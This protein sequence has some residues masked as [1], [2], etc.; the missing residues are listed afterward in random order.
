[1]SDGALQLSGSYAACPN[2]ARNVARAVLTMADVSDPKIQEG[3]LW[4]SCCRF[5]DLPG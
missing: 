3:V 4:R 2:S 1:M 5:M